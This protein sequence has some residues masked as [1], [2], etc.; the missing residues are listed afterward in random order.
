MNATWSK[1]K[2]MLNI[3]LKLS[4]NLNFPGNSDSKENAC[5]AEDQVWSLGQE[6]TLWKAIAT[7]SSILAGE[8]HG[9]RSLACYSPWGH[10]ELDTTEQLTYLNKWFSMF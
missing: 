7:H 1:N 4:H 2:E 9:Q 5:N 3:Y 10:K 8:S 6:D